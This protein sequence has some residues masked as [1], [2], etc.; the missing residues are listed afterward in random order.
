MLQHIH[1]AGLRLRQLIENNILCTQLFLK[2]ADPRRQ[3]AL[4]SKRAENATQFI[5]STARSFAHAR[6]RTIDFSCES[7]EGA[8]A[9]A[10]EYLAK[11]IEEL[12]D[13]AF[14]FSA[15]ESVVRVQTDVAGER[16]VIAITDRGRGMTT[17]QVAKI[18]AFVQFDRATYEQQGA[19]LGLAV[20]K[21]LVELHEGSVSISSEVEHGTVVR[22]N[23]PLS[24]PLTL[25]KRLDNTVTDSAREMN[26]STAPDNNPPCQRY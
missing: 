20:V 14:K 7:S 26:S 9:I 5:A 10:P 18:G 3:K 16:F 2:T 6:R 4:G 12:L 15:P 8:V 21:R 19:G 25:S 23:L 24:A 13:N 11:I 17:E 22:I 1:D